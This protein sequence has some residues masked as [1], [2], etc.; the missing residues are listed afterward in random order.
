MQEML[1]TMGSM[2]GLGRSPGEENGQ[3]TQVFLPGESQAWGL[4]TCSH[5]ESDT[6]EHTHNLQLPSIS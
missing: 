3:P 5:K 4:Y 1:E 6:T 2:P